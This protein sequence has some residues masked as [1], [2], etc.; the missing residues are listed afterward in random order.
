MILPKPGPANL[1]WAR[2]AI[3]VALV[4]V[5][6]SG[7][8]G[9]GSEQA[10]PVVDVPVFLADRAF[11]DLE[12]QCSF[13]ARPPG[14]AGHQAQLVWMRATL[15]PLA[16]RVVEQPFNTATA[17]GGPYD[18]VNLIA[19]FGGAAPGAATF[20]GAHWDTRPEA[21]E[22]PDPAKHTQ[23]VMGA[24]DGASGVAILLELARLLKATPP[25]HP[26]YLLFLDA[27]DSGKSGSGLLD[28][29]FCLGAN[30]LAQHW[31][32]DLPRP[33]RGAILDL[34]GGTK[35]NDRV[36]VRTD[37]GGNDVFDLRIELNSL[38]KAPEVVDQLWT[39]AEERGH[40]AFKRTTQFAVTDDH[41]AFNRVGI[42]TVDIIDFPPPVWHTADDVPE[43]CQPSALR[44]V[45][46]TVAAWLYQ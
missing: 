7:A 16:D 34:V 3:L 9:G 38:Q 43:Y 4:L 15:Q 14:S 28:Q 23:P 1:P 17:F 10:P 31:P 39:L 40:A 18:F 35:H 6:S 32:A 36:P 13:G 30:Y 26:V 25:L 42:P 5:G 27:E 33:T 29:G 12:K 21:D 19:V 20:V 44:E 2:L 37:L 22:D 24:N 41:L 46:D 8:C 45:G 11:A